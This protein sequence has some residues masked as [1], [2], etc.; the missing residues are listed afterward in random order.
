[1]LNNQNMNVLLFLSENILTFYCWDATAIRIIVVDNKVKM[2]VGKQNV[3]GNFFFFFQLQTFQ[4]LLLPI[5]Q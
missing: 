4:K 2:Y 5:V 1:M 3:L